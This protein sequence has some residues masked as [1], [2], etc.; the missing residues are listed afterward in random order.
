MLM[1]TGALELLGAAGL[2]IGRTAPWAALGLT[3][4]LV[5][6]FPA[7]LHVAFEHLTSDWFD[8]L[9]QRTLVQLV[10]LG[11]T[12]AVMLSSFSLPVHPKTSNDGDR[13]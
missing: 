5:R 9:V 8:E 7:N 6:M 13:P 10:F 4:M 1:I 12:S 11:A 2:S 3:L